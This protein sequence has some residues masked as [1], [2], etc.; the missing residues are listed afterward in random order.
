MDD[1]AHQ[2]TAAP[3]PSPLRL[4]GFLVTIVGGTLL[5]VGSLLAW[6]VIDL[7]GTTDVRGIDVLEGKVALGCAILVLIGIPAMRGSLTRRG[8]Y[9]WGAIIV[10]AGLLGAGLAAYDLADK[11]ARL[12]LGECAKQVAASTGIPESAE[13]RAQCARFASTDLGTGIYVT[14]AGGLL[15]AAG[16]A[17]GIAWARRAKLPSTHAVEADPE[18]PAASE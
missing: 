11:E 15:S 18:A 13:L 17:L 14:I 7:G 10:V 4:A 3:R 6:A 2:F 9:A 1:D 8:R 16:G 12:G 5:G